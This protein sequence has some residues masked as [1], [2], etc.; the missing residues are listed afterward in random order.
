MEV[1]GGDRRG[2]D[3]RILESSFD[4]VGGTCKTDVD[5]VVKS[6]KEG[7]RAAVGVPQVR[8]GVG[9]DDDSPGEE[10]STAV[11]DVDDEGVAVEYV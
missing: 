10:R 11:L 9:G 2:A 8:R 1:G 7:V 4:N 5:D 3:E 6:S